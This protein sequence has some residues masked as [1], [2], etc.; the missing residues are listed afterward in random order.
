MTAPGSLPSP[1]TL[2]ALSAV[3]ALARD[4]RAR[5]QAIPYGPDRDGAVASIERR[6]EEAA[7]AIRGM[8]L[9]VEAGVSRTAVEAP[10]AG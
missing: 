3:R 2:A 6:E 10:D 4:A 7:Q 1:P 8:S 5:A 9:A